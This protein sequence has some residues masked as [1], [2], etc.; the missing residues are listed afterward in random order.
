MIL[1]RMLSGVREAGSSAPDAVAQS[2]IIQRRYLNGMRD[3][4]ASE[5]SIGAYNSET[6][7][8]VE[9]LLDSLEHRIGRD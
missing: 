5:R 6:Y 2:L 4:L 9:S 8:K 7:R 3:A 1:P